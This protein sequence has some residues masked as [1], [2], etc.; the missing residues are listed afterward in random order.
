MPK[1][2]AD[3]CL[4]AQICLNPN[5]PVLSLTKRSYPQ[6]NSGR[7]GGYGLAGCTSKKAM[8][9]GIHIEAPKRIQVNEGFS[10]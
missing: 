4:I 5:L 10:I 7:N 6:E 3:H 2:V 8:E 1:N 9:K